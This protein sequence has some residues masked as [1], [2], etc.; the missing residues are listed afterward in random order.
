MVSHIK[1]CKYAD[2]TAHAIVGLL[3]HGESDLSYHETIKY[4]TQ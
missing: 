2:D 1:V 3:K 4:I